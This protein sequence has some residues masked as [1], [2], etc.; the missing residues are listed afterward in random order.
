MK[1]HFKVGRMKTIVVDGK[2]SFEKLGFAILDSYNI[3]LSHLFLF[4]FA[5]GDETNSA[6]LFGPMN[7]YRD[8]SMEATIESRNLEIGEA[9]TME[10]DYSGNWKRKVKLIKITE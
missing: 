2:D 10:Y 7:D 8:V 3:R 1:Y 9:M 4:V 6:T 5:N